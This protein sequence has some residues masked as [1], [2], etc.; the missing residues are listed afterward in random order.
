LE[1]LQSGILSNIAQE[2][3]I[4]I[5]YGVVNSTEYNNNLQIDKNNSKLTLE[6]Y[7]AMLF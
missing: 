2:D 5:S 4:M 6:N 3:F 1:D 7:N